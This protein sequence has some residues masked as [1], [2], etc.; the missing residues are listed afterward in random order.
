MGLA[1]ATSNPVNSVGGLTLS[2]QVIVSGNEGEPLNPAT[3]ASKVST[4]F[5][6]TSSSTGSLTMSAGHGLITGQVVD[7]YWQD[8]AGLY[9][10]RRRVLLGTVSGNTVIIAG[11]NTTPATAGANL[12]ITGTV[13]HVMAPVMVPAVF[14]GSEIVE[15]VLATDQHG[16]FAFLDGSNV[17]QFEKAIGPGELWEY[18]GA[19]GR[20]CALVT[21]AI[22]VHKVYFSH[23][24]TVAAT[25][26]AVALLDYT[27]TGT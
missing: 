16:S 2:G 26:K 14:D 13:I 8:T 25:M 24:G 21:S 20:A 12:P 1:S 19:N 6:N 10:S 4:A 18:N 23:G 11:N 3:P 17:V 7:L 22:T 9:H 27:G 5:T 15:L